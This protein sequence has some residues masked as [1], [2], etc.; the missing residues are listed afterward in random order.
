MVNKGG[1]NMITAKEAY[2]NTRR[3][4]ISEID[5]DP[6]Y[7]SHRAIR[8]IETLIVH[9]MENGE[10]AIVFTDVNM[11]R[12]EDGASRTYKYLRRQGYTVI[13]PHENLEIAYGKEVLNA[14]VIMVYWHNAKE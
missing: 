4:A 6:V 8:C 7:D 12:T 13:R 11:F 5:P 2:E 1:N 10:T 14:R 3:E 9:A